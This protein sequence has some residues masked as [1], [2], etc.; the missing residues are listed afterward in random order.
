MARTRTLLV[1]A[2]VACLSAPL[3]V[4]LGSPARAATTGPSVLH[5]GVVTRQDVASR[6]G[7]ED[8]TVVEPDLAASPLDPDVAVAAAHDSRYSDGGAVAITSAWTA[9]GGATWHHA[10][11]PG[12]TLATGG[13]YQ[14]A[15]DPVLAFG[16]DGTAY[17]SVLV[18]DQP[19]CHSA[20]AV[21]RSG[22]GGRTW[23]APSYVHRTTTCDV[24][25]DKNFIVVDGNQA[26][27]HRG[28][29]YQFWSLFRFSGNNFLGSPQKVRW[30]DDHGRTWSDTSAVTPA[31]HATQNSVAM[32]LSNGT[33][34]D[35]YYDFGAGAAAPDSTPGLAPD[36][37]RPALRAGPA[38]ID[39]TGPIFASRSTDGGVTWQRL[40]EV[41]NNGGGFAPGVRCCLFSATLDS[42]TQRMYVS[43]NGS[44]P[45]DTDPVQV[46]SSDDGVLWTSPVTVTRGDVPGVQRVNNDVVAQGGHVY[47][48]YGT[49]TQ[50]DASGGVVQQ[51]L[52]TSDNG[53]RTFAGPVSLGQRSNLK[54][55]A[56]ARGFFPGDYTGSAISGGRLY[57]AWARS[58]VP[59]T[60]ST[61]PFHQVIDGATLQR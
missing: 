38:V 29:V 27:P 61:S 39:A 48:S 35:T 17:L 21:L 40:G 2:A 23:S 24:S 30:S 31:D 6:A 55:A 59:P 49:R 1:L 51:Q 47:V 34:I 43:W 5:V 26:S 8:D 11:V 13:P 42:V 16:P 32:V 44:G 15:S 50:I 4:G 3:A 37:A 25:D 19:A 60:S 56:Q 14:R 52:S 28:R 22:N 45:G 33:I 10:P 18:F 9:D 41:T 12:L 7:S 58:S 36:T 53:G 54:Y 46:S 20:V 57:L